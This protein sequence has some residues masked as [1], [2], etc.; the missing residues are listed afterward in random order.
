MWETIEQT[1]NPHH[2]QQKTTVAQPLGGLQV[3]RPVSQHQS[4]F[5]TRMHTHTCLFLCYR[6]KGEKGTI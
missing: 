5:T 2:Q 3:S 6:E 1:T 4:E